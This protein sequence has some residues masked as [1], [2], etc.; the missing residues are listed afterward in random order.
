MSTTPAR[1]P[2]KLFEGVPFEEIPLASLPLETLKELEADKFELLQELVALDAERRLL[3]RREGI[4][5]PEEDLLELRR[6]IAI[7]RLQ[8]SQLKRARAAAREAKSRQARRAEIKEDTKLRW[9]PTD[10]ML[11]NLL[12]LLEERKLL[13]IIKQARDHSRKFWDQW[14]DD[15]TRI[16][17]A[18]CQE[19]HSARRQ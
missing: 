2:K 17:F 15:R 1:S 5:T 18:A 6:D 12:N 14:S 10:A 16:I 9:E 3:W 7:A 13:D 4:P 11:A 8:H 19:S